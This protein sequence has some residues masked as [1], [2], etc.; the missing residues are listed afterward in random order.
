MLEAL[1]RILPSNWVEPDPRLVR[2]YHLVFC[3]GRAE[4]EADNGSGDTG[5]LNSR[6]V[7]QVFLAVD[8]RYPNTVES[9]QDQNGKDHT[10]PQRRP[11]I[12]DGKP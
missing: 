9:P 4:D 6:C 5:A 8:D 7:T 12:Q 11:E 1:L 10:S 2:F 3:V